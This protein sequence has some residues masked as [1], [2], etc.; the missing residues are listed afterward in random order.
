M[1]EN[2]IVYSNLSTKYGTNMCC[3]EVIAFSMCDYESLGIDSNGVNVN[4]SAYGFSPDWI[5]G[6]T[7]IPR[8]FIAKRTAH[9]DDPDSCVSNPP[10]LLPMA[11]DCNSEG[12]DPSDANKRA[13]DPR[14]I[15][16][17]E[18]S[19]TEY[20]AD[21]VCPDGKCRNPNGQCV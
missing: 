18:L 1:N 21:P 5:W 12:V 3:T 17:Y 7:M 9:S 2:E 15:Y 13:G 4:L 8:W 10:I 20:W 11:G 16:S 6:G 14:E 19:P